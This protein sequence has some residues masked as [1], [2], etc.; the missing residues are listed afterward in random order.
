M[1]KIVKDPDYPDNEN[2]I[3][4]DRYK[5]H[6]MEEVYRGEVEKST[7]EIIFDDND[8]RLDEIESDIQNLEE[9]ERLREQEK[10]RITDSSVIDEEYAESD[11]EVPLEEI[12]QAAPAEEVAPEA[13]PVEA[14]PEEILPEVPVEVPLEEALAD[15]IPDEEALAD[16]IPDE[17]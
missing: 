13:A 16:A 11:T 5:A 14:P 3:P 12:P 1:I 2:E 17:E 7:E 6:D 8:Q 10:V 4:D 15:A 9:M